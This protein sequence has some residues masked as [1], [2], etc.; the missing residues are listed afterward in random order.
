MSAI[1]RDGS[2]GAEE[3]RRQLRRTASRTK[4]REGGASGSTTVV[5]KPKRD[6]KVE[7][8]S[9]NK[10]ML[11]AILKSHQT[12]RDLSSTVWGTL[13]IKVSS[14]EADNVQEQTQTYAEKVRQ[15]GRGHKRGPPFV[16]AYLGL[17]KSLQQRGI[18]AYWDRLEP[19]SPTQKSDD[20]RFCRLD[21]TYK[22]DI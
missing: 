19:L 14:L 9:L 16:W 10:I 4:Q 21:K 8:K 20:V 15:E 2:R 12:M 6:G 3:P 11:K 22:A 18:A 7:Q 17:V 13:L 1:K 5:P